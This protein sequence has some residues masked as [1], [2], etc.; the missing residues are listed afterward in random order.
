MEKE[1]DEDFK[2]EHKYGIVSDGELLL[3]HAAKLYTRNAFNKFKDEWS[4]VN[5]Y[6]VEEKGCDGEYQEF[7]V[8]TKFGEFEEF[9]VKLSLQN[10]KEIDLIPDHFTLSRW[11]Q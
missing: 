4:Q 1:S 10:Y 9:V 5:R 3:K 6:K 7:S 11:K 8:I 2:S